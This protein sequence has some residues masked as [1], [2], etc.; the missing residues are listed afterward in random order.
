M[1]ISL[2]P[3]IAK[4]PT[5]IPGAVEKGF[6]K[7]SSNENNYGPSQEV[8]TALKKNLRNIK[9]YPSQDKEVREALAEYVRVKS[10]NILVGNGSDE[11]IDLIL[12]TFNGPVLS[13][14]PT[15]P[16]YKI[17]SLILGMKYLE[18]PLNPDFSFP[19]E[20]YLE[21][22]KN[23]NLLFLS[24]PNNPTGGVV[25]IEEIKEILKLG[26]LTV[27]D[28]AYCEF[29]GKSM[30]ELLPEY[31]NL[32]ILRTMSKAFALAGLRIGY[33]IASK[34]IVNH[35]RKVKPPFN[36][37]FLAEVAAIAA[38]QDL[39][40]MRKCV[41]KIVKD[42]ER[43][44]K[45]LSRKF[46]VIPSQANFIFFDVH[47]SSSENIYQYFLKNKIILRNF[48]HLKG[49]KGEWLRVSVGTKKEVDEFLRVLR[50]LA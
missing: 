50:A 40:Y 36:V 24:N 44:E 5:Y 31:P 49:F 13:Y 25:E 2:K 46:R 17:C 1:S 32:I 38:L 39:E 3:W 22:A 11:L 48:G 47:P 19:I 4:V 45:E 26:K 28:E 30:V 10:E 20:D 6:I 27:I 8:L 41:R 18:I 21:K 12:K 9:L 14:Y 29:S 43:I 7:L 16:E 35:V 37:N 33:M 15:F 42:R 23:A 34:N